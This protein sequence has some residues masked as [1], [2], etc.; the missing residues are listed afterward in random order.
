M[1]LFLVELA[2][3]ALFGTHL[4]IIYM[5]IIGVVLAVALL[6]LALPLLL[7]CVLWRAGFQHVDLHYI[8]PFRITGFYIVRETRLSYVRRIHF[9][10]NNLRLCKDWFNTD[11][12]RRRLIVELGQPQLVLEVDS[13]MFEEIDFLKLGQEARL[14]S[15]LRRVLL[16]ALDYYVGCFG[17]GDQ[18]EEPA[19]RRAPQ[20]TSSFSAS[21]KGLCN[22]TMMLLTQ[23]IEV[24]VKELSVELTPHQQSRHTSLS[25]NDLLQQK[26]MADFT[27]LSELLTLRFALNSTQDLEFTVED[28][29]IRVE[30]LSVR[31]RELYKTVLEVRDTRVIMQMPFTFSFGQSL[32]KSRIDLTVG[33]V[34]LDVVPSNF[35]EVFDLVV[36]LRK[37]IVCHSVLRASREKVSVAS[38]QS[39]GGAATESN[40]QGRTRGRDGGSAA[41]IR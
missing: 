19:V 41:G 8:H 29:C 24:E 39:D 25:S 15:N 12:N 4:G 5:L 28:K 20:P 33:S 32:S 17:S 14:L 37:S 30:Q 21:L 11:I 38:D 26:A 31:Y 16:E 36:P 34:L 9:Q 23:L 22:F 6:L 10:L 18:P 27:V 40:D 2:V 13:R 7:K 35:D 1:G 3:P